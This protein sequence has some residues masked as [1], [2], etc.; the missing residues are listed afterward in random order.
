M[1]LWRG[2]DD[3]FAV[4]ADVPPTAVG[5]APFLVS[6]AP[7][8][9]ASAFDHGPSSGLRTEF[10]FIHGGSP[11]RCALLPSESQPGGR[12]R[13]GLGRRRP[14]RRTPLLERLQTS[15]RYALDPRRRDHGDA[16][17]MRPQH[18]AGA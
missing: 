14:R 16:H 5:R 15:P 10:A 9:V 17:S 12:N 7:L 8:Q 13:S 11:A 6:T 2:L 4:H 1:P 3:L 18:L